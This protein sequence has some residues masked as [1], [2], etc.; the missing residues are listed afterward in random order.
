MIVV[1]GVVDFFLPIVLENVNMLRAASIMKV[2]RV[3]RAVRALRALR[4]IFVVK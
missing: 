1:C 4:V 3:I 2:L